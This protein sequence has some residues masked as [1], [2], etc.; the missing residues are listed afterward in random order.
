MNSVERTYGRSLHTAKLPTAPLC[1]ADALVDKHDNRQPI[2]ELIFAGAFLIKNIICALDVCI[3]P[4]GL[5]VIFNGIGLTPSERATA[6]PWR[7]RF[8][9]TFLEVIIKPL[10]S[11]NS[12]PD[13]GKEENQ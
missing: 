7:R 10:N 5:P 12:L 2:S 13:L 8:E 3:R 1:G 4:K 11:R 6:I 9:W